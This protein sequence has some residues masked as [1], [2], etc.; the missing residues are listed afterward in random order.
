[1]DYILLDGEPG[2]GAG[3]ARAGHVARAAGHG[4]VADGTAAGGAARMSKNMNGTTLARLGML[5]GLSAVTTA[6]L[7]AGQRLVEPGSALR[8][9]P[10]PP[11]PHGPCDQNGAGLTSGPGCPHV[12]VSL[13]RTVVLDWLRPNA[14][15]APRLALWSFG[16]G[17]AVLLCCALVLLLLPFGD[18]NEWQA[19]TFNLAGWCLLAQMVCAFCSLAL[20]VGGM[21]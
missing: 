1:M 14:S 11:A 10:L 6:A 4:P 7:A 19:E 3:G 12:L 17:A 21:R 5:A 9:I 8:A 16:L 20:V 2:A 13:Y 18:D 15:G